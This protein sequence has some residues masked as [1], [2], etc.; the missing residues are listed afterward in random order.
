MEKII[1]KHFFML[2]KVGL[3]LSLM[4]ITTLSLMPVESLPQTSVSDKIQH[5]AAFLLLAYI[6]D[7]SFE[8]TPFNL[9]KC[10]GL[11]FYGLMIEVLQWYSGYRF[12]E[13]ADLV[14][15]AA[16]IATYILMIPVIKKLPVVNYRWELLPQPAGN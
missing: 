10:F 3:V 11:I 7:C 6:V 9:K 15:D 5:L 16:G 8:K 14:A 2:A 12:F 13:L 1:R 4:I